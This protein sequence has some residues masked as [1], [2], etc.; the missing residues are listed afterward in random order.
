MRLSRMDNAMI[1]KAGSAL[2]VE[3]IKTT[4]EKK[5]AEKEED[6]VV[7]CFVRDGGML[8]G[9]CVQLCTLEGKPEESD[10]LFTPPNSSLDPN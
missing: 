2:P 10:D 1:N 6:L 8:P 7:W 4:L 5:K 3:G 9:L